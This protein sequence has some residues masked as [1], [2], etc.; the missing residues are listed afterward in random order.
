MLGCLTSNYA[1]AIV[2]MTDIDGDNMTSSYCSQ[3]ATDDDQRYKQNSILITNSSHVFTNLCHNFFQFFIKFPLPTLFQFVHIQ[4][5][6][7]GPNHLNFDNL[8]TS[9]KKCSSILTLEKD[10]VS[11]WLTLFFS[12]LNADGYRRFCW[13]AS[14][15]GWLKSSFFWGYILL[16]IH[17]GSL[18][19]KL[20]TR[21][22]PHYIHKDSEL[23]AFSFT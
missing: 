15:Q 14:R 12:Y 4:N 19:E 21:K 2:T 13:T 1:P 16:Q 11:L 22:V 9:Y 10:F 5:A 8:T 20:G 6:H 3:N 23:L 18:A 17:G 7:Y